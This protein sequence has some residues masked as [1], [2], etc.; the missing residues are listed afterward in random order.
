MDDPSDAV[1]VLIPVMHTND[2][3]EANLLSIYREIP[4]KRLLLGDAGCI[5]RTVEIARRFPRARCSTTGTTCLSGTASA[6]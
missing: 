5:D 2:L 1:D 3:W 6:N 4:V